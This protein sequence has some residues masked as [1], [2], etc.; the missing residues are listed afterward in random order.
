MLRYFLPVLLVICVLAFIAAGCG[1]EAEEITIDLP[2][3]EL[4][5]FAL[6]EEVEEEAIVGEQPLTEVPP[7]AEPA[8]VSA[9]VPDE[10]AEPLP[11]LETTYFPPPASFEPPVA[12]GKGGIRFAEDIL[13]PGPP[14]PEAKQ[15]KKRKGARTKE[16]VDGGIR[17]RKQRR[18]VEVIDEE[19]EEY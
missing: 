4:T 18:G 13:A 9:E 17:L 14:K 2:E 3:E 10:A 7:I 6:R 11:A 19:E 8:L 5:A 16:D 1:R 12:S 15:K